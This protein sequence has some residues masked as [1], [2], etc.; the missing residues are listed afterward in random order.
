M[1]E[2]CNN[3]PSNMSKVIKTFYLNKNM[4]TCHAFHFVS[5]FKDKADNSCRTNVCGQTKY[6]WPSHCVSLDGFCIVLKYVNGQF[7]FSIM[8]IK[9]SN[10]YTN[11]F[12]FFLFQHSAH[13]FYCHQYGKRWQILLDSIHVIK[14]LERIDV[15]II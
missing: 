5:G 6:E 1:V 3:I 12:C 14:Q 2:F 10:S 13:F 4:Q 11:N 7:V 15:Q 8:P 9:R